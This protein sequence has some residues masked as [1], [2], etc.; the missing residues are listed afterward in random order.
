MLFCAYMIEDRGS[1]GFAAQKTS[2]LKSSSPST[3]QEGFSQC[4]TLVFWWSS[5]KRFFFA[6]CYETA[7]EGES[8]KVKREEEE[9]KK[10]R[11]S[12]TGRRKK[13]TGY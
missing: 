7:R 3:I 4:D 13:G 12:D 2:E 10:C 8:S 11:R 6:S 9:G 1:H 5:Q